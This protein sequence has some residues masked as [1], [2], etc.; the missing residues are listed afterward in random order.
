MPYGQDARIGLGF[1]NSHGTEVTDIG[2]F[3]LMPFLSESV[4]P[5]VPELLSQN[6]EGMIRSFSGGLPERFQLIE[7]QV[8]NPLKAFEA[9]LAHKLEIMKNKEKLFLAREEKIPPE[10]E[11]LVEKYYEALSKTKK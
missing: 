1:Q 5:D 6:M 8:L 2:S 3:Y 7:E 9:E 10:Y 11:A 4:T